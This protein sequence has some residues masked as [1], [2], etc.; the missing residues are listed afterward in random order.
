MAQ[1]G[2]GMM[3]PGLMAEA[4]AGWG[5][6]MQGWGAEL[7]REQAGYQQRMMPY[8]MMPGF[9]QQA[10]PYPTVDQGGGG[11]GDFLGGLAGMGMAGL[12]YGLGGPFGGMIGGGLGNWFGGGGFRSDPS[13]P[14]P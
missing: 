9:S 13:D 11:F 6:A 3:Q 12:G 14:H 1:T 2:W 8:Q 7:G 4:Q 5:G 10:M